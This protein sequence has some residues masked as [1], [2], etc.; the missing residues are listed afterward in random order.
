MDVNDADFHDIDIDHDD[1]HKADT[2]DNSYVVL[3]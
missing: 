3:E 1:G 2:H